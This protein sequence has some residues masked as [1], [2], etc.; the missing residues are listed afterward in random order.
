MLRANPYLE[1]T[2]SELKDQRYLHS[3]F[4]WI[5]RIRDKT[6]VL[7]PTGVPKDLRQYSDITP[8]FGLVENSSGSHRKIYDKM[9]DLDSWG[10][11]GLP[12]NF[13]P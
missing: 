12:P 1:E 10:T 3:H 13:Y 9:Q 11:R 2:F 4:F 7:D 5:T 8:Y 6:F